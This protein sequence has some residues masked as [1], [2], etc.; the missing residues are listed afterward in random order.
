MKS[1]IQVPSSIWLSVSFLLGAT[2]LFAQDDLYYNPATAPVIISTTTTTTTTTTT[3]T[4]TY[5]DPYSENGVT[6]VYDESGYYDEED[7]YA[8]EYSSRIRRFHNRSMVSDYYD[9]F[10]SDL[11][12][13]DPYYLPG[14]S[15]YVVGM[16]D[17]WSYRRWRRWNRWNRWNE[18]GSPYAYS[19][20]GWNAGFNTWGWG[21]GYYSSW[22]NP[23]YNPCVV[24]N[25]FYDPY[26]TWNGFNPYY[27]QHHHHYYYGNN[28][29]N[30]DG[31]Y[32]PSTYTGPRRG[33][34]GID[35]GYTRFNDRNGRITTANPGGATVELQR[36]NGRIVRD[37]EPEGGQ[38]ERVRGDGRKP[39]VAAPEVQRD[40]SDVQRT[41]PKREVA[42]VRPER[43]SPSEVRPERSSPS[44]VR[45]EK[46]EAPSSR[47]SREVAPERR[48]EPEA[49]PTREARPERRQSP[50]TT[51]DNGFEN[52][53]SRNES[54][55]F[56]RGSDSPSR[57]SSGNSGGGFS[58]SRSNSGGGGNSGRSGR[59]G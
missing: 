34:S 54:P 13:Y 6:S 55:S 41:T 14:S 16:D 31:G 38:V 39:T 4:T 28:P 19:P 45:P 44:T 42:P 18:W 52:R 58:P 20:W 15:I 46:R 2:S 7:D 50:S 17:Y 32:R 43:S 30:N 40:R 10:Y 26:W 5:S 24:N 3:E 51:R 29:V 48:S 12:F 37:A 59:G 47:P 22:G 36:P 57:G 25:Y 21:V 49:R 35:Q 11:Y 8:Y 9:P 23:W 33:G 27:G 53:P 1:I 56:N